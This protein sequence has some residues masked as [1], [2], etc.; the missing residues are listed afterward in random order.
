[1]WLFRPPRTLV[2]RYGDVMQPF[3]LEDGAVISPL[4]RV[5]GAPPRSF[6]G[7]LFEL[8]RR[9]LDGLAFVNRI[10]F[11]NPLALR[12]ELVDVPLCFV[13]CVVA[14]ADMPGSIGRKVST[15]NTGPQPRR[16]PAADRCFFRCGG[17]MGFV[18]SPS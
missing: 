11:A 14:L 7:R 12:G 18:T 6:A 13:G 10:D 5:I 8:L 2:C 3:A 17:P 1:M 16:S 4:R 9:Y 15:F